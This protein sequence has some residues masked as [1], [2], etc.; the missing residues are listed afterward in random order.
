MLYF[1]I[2]P[3]RYPHGMLTT[4]GGGGSLVPTQE[5]KIKQKYNLNAEIPW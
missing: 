2:L 4:W 3:E 1:I 5:K